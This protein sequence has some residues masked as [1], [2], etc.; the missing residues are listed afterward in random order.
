MRV[1]LIS[2]NIERLPDP[3]AP[4]GP[5][6]LCAA[7]EARGHEVRFLD[8]CFADPLQDALRTSVATFAPEVIALSIRNIDNVA[9]PQTSTYL[10]FY[11]MIAAELRG[12]SQAPIFLGGAGFTIMPYA[13]LHYL[14]ADGGIAGEGEV[15]LAHLLHI[16]GQQKVGRTGE[17]EGVKYEELTLE[18]YGPGNSALIIEGSTDNRN[19]TVSEIKYLL[20]EHNGKFANSGSVSW[21]FDH[22]GIINLKKPASQT[23]DELELV[24]I[25]VGA[26]DL[27]WIDEENLEIYTA[28]EEL[29]SI[30]KKLEENK[31]PV[32][33]ASLGWKP[34]NEI[35]IEEQK[36]KE[37][38]ERL[39]E[40]LDEND[41]VSEIYSNVKE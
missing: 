12:L 16:L 21:M 34:K 26:Q 40:A 7:L 28:P 41:D 24:V 20:G 36:T 31:I 35:S 2:A 4:L 3:V 10:P 13:I 39:L 19:R 6:Y 33:E 18:A 11:K 37:Q 38:L 22:L 23:K 32:S 30:K 27:K 8:L 15:S 17:I 14:E 9:Y 1:L 29:E 25:D 5:A